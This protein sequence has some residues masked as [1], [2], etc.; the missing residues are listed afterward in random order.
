MFVVKNFSYNGFMGQVL[1]GTAPYTAEFVEWTLDP[2]VAL[3]QCSDGEVR[4]I[5]TF[6]LEGNRSALPRQDYAKLGGKK[7]YFSL[8]AK[9]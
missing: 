9:S 6:A 7:V 4:L 3:F 8:P 2:G 1:S 5:P